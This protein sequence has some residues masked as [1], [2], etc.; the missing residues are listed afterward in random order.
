MRAKL[1]KRRPDGSFCI[2]MQL[3]IVTNDSTVLATR[4]NGWIDAWVLANRYWECPMA[5]SV[6]G[7]FDFYDEFIWPP[8]CVVGNAG[9]VS[10][11]VEGRPGAGKWW[12]D[13]ILSR[14][15]RDLIAMFKEVQRPVLE[16]FRYCLEEQSPEPE[17]EEIKRVS[18][19]NL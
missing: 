14:M 19:D 18:M 2:E 15:M 1:P 8:Y 11:K 4:M 6:G 12:K 9:S 3:S 7:V 13:W 10:I 17:L 16:E 5:K